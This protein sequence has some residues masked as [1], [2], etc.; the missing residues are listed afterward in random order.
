MF[1]TRLS[2]SARFLLVVA[3]GFIFQAGVSVASLMDL[4]NS[5]MQDRISEV[6]NLLDVGYSTVALYY[7][8]ARKGVMTDAEAVSY[9]HLTLP[10]TP[11]V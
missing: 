7:E 6:K 1:L 9:T 11:Y 10:T 4:K 3:I 8:Q 2:V 5:L